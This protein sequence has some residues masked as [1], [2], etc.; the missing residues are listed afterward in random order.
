MTEQSSK[1]PQQGQ[2][3]GQQ[4]GNFFNKKEAFNIQDERIGAIGP[5]DINS[6]IFWMDSGMID[7]NAKVLAVGSTEPQPITQ[8]IEEHGNITG[9]PPQNWFLWTDTNSPFNSM[10]NRVNKCFLSRQSL[11][12]QKYTP[13]PAPSTIQDFEI[14]LEQNPEV[15]PEISNLGLNKISQPFAQW[16]YKTLIDLEASIGPEDVL[17]LLLNP[18]PKFARRFFTTKLNN[19]QVA[20]K[21]FSVYNQWR[22]YIPIYLENTVNSVNM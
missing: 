22:V 15:S 21:L 18:D 2:A 6:L 17:K 12:D 16:M 13:P 14:F 5:L 8:V 19:E 1:I 11:S 9:N 4:Q 3:Q 10:V 20:S 7:K